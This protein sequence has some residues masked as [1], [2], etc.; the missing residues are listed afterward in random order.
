MIPD[1]LDWRHICGL[2]KV[3]EGHLCRVR[4]SIVLLKNSS[5]ESLYEWQQTWLHDVMDILLGLIVPRI[6]TRDDHVL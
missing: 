3:K 4:L 1:M 2:G 6:N 5:W